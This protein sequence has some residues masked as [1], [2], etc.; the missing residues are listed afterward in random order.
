MTNAQTV[1]F[2][3]LP[4]FTATP[5]AAWNVNRLKWG[6][7]RITRDCVPNVQESEHGVKCEKHPIH[8]T[9]SI[10]QFVVGESLGVVVEVPLERLAL[11][12]VP[13]GLPLRDVAIVAQSL[14]FRLVVLP[15]PEIDDTNMLG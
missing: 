3:A 5:L 7:I 12:P 9:T 1:A 8:Y 11:Q 10:Y 2:F 15:Q 14:R 13:Q 4:Y 6:K